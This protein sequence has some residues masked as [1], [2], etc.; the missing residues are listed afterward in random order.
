MRGK[1]A[2]R[3][4]ENFA[5]FS[6]YSHQLSAI[7]TS[8]A[9]KCGG[10]ERD[11]F[12]FSVGRQSGK[13][14][15][16]LAVLARVCSHFRGKMARRA[17]A[18]SGGKGHPGRRTNSVSAVFERFWKVR[19]YSGKRAKNRFSRFLSVFYWAAESERGA[20]KTSQSRLTSGCHRIYGEGP[21]RWRRVRGSLGASISAFDLWI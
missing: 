10:K 16:G 7:L 18:I 8:E 17:E 3:G 21:F 20:V 9:E 4:S 13:Y 1:S 14:F 19:F 2:V 15:Y 5:P 11:P 12:A 6:G